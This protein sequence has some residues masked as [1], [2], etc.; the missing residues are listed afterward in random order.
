MSH[1]MAGAFRTVSVAAIRQSVLSGFLNLGCM[2]QDPTFKD[3]FAHGFIVVGAT[4]VVA[5]AGTAVASREGRAV[6]RAP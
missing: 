3:I 5:R 1:P 2:R 6:A 4:L